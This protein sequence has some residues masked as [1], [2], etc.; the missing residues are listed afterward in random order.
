MG[1]DE[2]AKIYSEKPINMFRL[3]DKGAERILGFVRMN[4]VVS[5]IF[6]VCAQHGGF[7]VN[8]GGRIVSQFQWNSI[9]LAFYHVGDFLYISH[10]FNLEVIR[11]GVDRNSQPA[12]LASYRPRLIGHKDNSVIIYSRPFGGNKQYSAIKLLS[13]TDEIEIDHDETYLSSIPSSFE[14]IYQSPFKTRYDLN[15]YFLKLAFSFQPI[16]FSHIISTK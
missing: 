3:Y 16:K 15:Y 14:P 10:F 11:V 5:N 2:L 1:D 6:L 7:V 13:G 4:K 9:P 8:N 12:A